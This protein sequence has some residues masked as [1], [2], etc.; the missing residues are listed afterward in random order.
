MARNRGFNDDINPY[1]DETRYESV[2]YGCT[3][4]PTIPPDSG[5]YP[6]DETRPPE[7]DNPNVRFD[8]N[9]KSTEPTN[10]GGYI[11]TEPIENNKDGNGETEIVDVVD[12]PGEEKIRPVVGWLIGTK[13]PCKYR[14]FRLHSERNYIGRG[15]DQDIVIPDPTVSRKSVVQ[16]AFAS[17]N[18]TFHLIPCDGASIVSY[19]NGEELFTPRKLEDG[20][21]IQIGNSELMFKALCGEGF[22][23]DDEKD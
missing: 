5:D 18:A 14:D 4:S 1:V 3:V 16:V 23:W 13:G 11:G 21:R 15:E 10:G 12:V 17:R 22:S 6:Y 8:R 20:D 9:Y 7:D 19:C 2:P